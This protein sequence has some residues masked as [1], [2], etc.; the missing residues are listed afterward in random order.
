MAKLLRCEI[1]GF[2]HEESIMGEN[3]PKCGA[4]KEKFRELTQEEAEKVVR[5]EKT[6][7]LHMRLIELMNQVVALT[8]CG[9]EDNLDPAC[10]KVFTKAKA[11]ASL[12]KQMSKAELAG[13]VAKGKW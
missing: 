13:H 9:I 11:S 5:S 6:N 8:E 7:D 2:I 4:T 3:C 10:V 12:I 1:C